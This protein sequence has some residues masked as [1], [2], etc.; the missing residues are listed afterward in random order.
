MLYGWLARRPCLSPQSPRGASCSDCFTVGSQGIRRASLLGSRDVLSEN[1]YVH[2]Y[3]CF[4]PKNQRF[5]NITVTE[6]DLDPK[7][8][9]TISMT[10]RKMRWN[11]TDYKKPIF[12]LIIRGEILNMTV[13]RNVQRFCMESICGWSRFQPL[14]L[15]AGYVSAIMQP[16]NRNQWKVCSGIQVSKKQ[17]YSRWLEKE[18]T[19][20]GASVIER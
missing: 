10:V 2:C 4:T 9:T 3:I 16:R 7:V 17:M 8:H 18:L 14:G 6:S 19:L 15:S 13:Q 20:W 1:G 11:V 12:D 5:F